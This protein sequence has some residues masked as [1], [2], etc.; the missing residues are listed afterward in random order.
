MSSLKGAA[1]AYT[2]MGLSV[3]ASVPRSKKPL[4]EWGDYRGRIPDIATV[5]SWFDPDKV[6]RVIDGREIRGTPDAN[7]QVVCG[8]SNRLMVVDL[9][10][11]GAEQFLN[12]RGVEFDFMAPRV[13]SGRI[14]GGEHVWMRVPEKYAQL[15]SKN[16]VFK[17]KKD[18]GFAI[19]VKNENGLATLPPSVHANGSPYTWLSSLGEIS[20]I[21]YAPDSF[22]ELLLASPSYQGDTGEMAGAQRV[23]A[24]E[25]EE[26][27][28][29]AERGSRNEIATRLA[30]WLI[31]RGLT[32][33]EAFVTL[34][35]WRSL[36]D[37]PFGDRFTERELRTVVK[38]ISAK[39]ARKRETKEREE[40][41]RR[42]RIFAGVRVADPER[43]RAWVM[44]ERPRVLPSPFPTLNAALGGGFRPGKYYLIA[45]YA[46]VGKSALAL[47]CAV[48]AAFRS[49][50]AGFGPVWYISREMT[51]MDL[52]ERLYAQESRVPA[53]AFVEGSQSRRA[54]EA[55]EHVGPRLTKLDMRYFVDIP[56]ATL[57]R[58]A[59]VAQEVP[60]SLVVVDYVQQLSGDRR[61][62]DS[63]ERLE[64]ESAE[65]K[66]IT[67]DLNLPVVALSSMARPRD[68]ASSKRPELTQIRGSE[69]LRHDCD[70]GMILDRE[71]G[72]NVAT[73]YIDKGR[74]IGEADVAMSFANQWVTFSDKRAEIEEE[75][76][77][78]E[79]RMF[80][81]PEDDD[82]GPEGGWLH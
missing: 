53:N 62:R 34:L 82:E 50:A 4:I 5:E 45:A 63:R 55:I 22:I 59:I 37:V 71:R 69:Q 38:S 3:V 58:E 75:M 81:V 66:A 76:E 15:A 30:G 67:V 31:S 11:E 78:D 44:S 65:I 2:R 57:L 13:R 29:G 20:E 49:R 68:A 26:M 60:P 28:R 21:P 64:N 1:I 51:V 12:A 43:M 77:R 23:G 40:L 56:N 42:R 24:S 10:G 7:L 80:D 6:L 41:E 33:E 18:L 70:V 72:Q 46:G 35:P 14:D 8:G 9:D 32:Q 36:V 48:H 17:T 52:E 16:D 74:A 19:D 54:L 39:D 79:A 47:Q 27:F 73:L 25:I 61:I